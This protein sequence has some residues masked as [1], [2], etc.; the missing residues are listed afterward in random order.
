MV[1]NI[2]DLGPHPRWP[3]ADALLVHPNPLEGTSFLL[4]YF[5]PPRGG[6]GPEKNA[7]NQWR[8]LMMGPDVCPLSG[9]P[10][11]VS[12]FAGHQAPLWCLEEVSGRL[13][14]DPPRTRRAGTNPTEH[15]LAVYLLLRIADSPLHKMF[16]SPSPGGRFTL[17][18]D[19]VWKLQPFT[20]LWRVTAKNHSDNS[21]IFQKLQ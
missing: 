3:V 19:L 14:W 12:P 9:P 5:F 13:L 18:H 11:S 17:L 20:F 10:A 15:D 1:S 16:A 8:F 7:T 21:L 2:N 4:Y 6:Y